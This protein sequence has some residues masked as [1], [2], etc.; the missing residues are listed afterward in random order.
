MEKKPRNRLRVLLVDDDED[1][2]LLTK[3]MLADCAY[4]SDRREPVGFRLDWVSSYE[5]AL[6][7]FEGQQHDVYLL[8]YHLGSRDGLQLLREVTAKGCTK[9]V[10]L[11]TGRGSYD[12]DIEAMKAGATDYLVKGEL[13]APLLERTIRYSIERKRAEEEIRQSA[14]RAQGLAALS[15]AFAEASLDL[16]EVLK[17]IPRR[18]AQAFGD[19][20][21]LRLVSEDGQWLTPVAF[22][23]PRA[24]AHLLG[25]KELEA[26]RQ[27]AQEGLAGQVFRTSRPLLVEEAPVPLRPSE[28]EP[29]HGFEE[30]EFYPW[31]NGTPV[32]SL[33]IVPLSAQGRLIG[34]L[35]ALRFQA[36]RPYTAGDVV[37]FQDVAGR[38]VLA[39]ENALLHAEVQKTAITDALTE[40][41]NRRGLFELGRREIERARRFS[42]PLSAIMVDLDHFK[43]VNDTHGHAAGDQVLRI[44]G[45][46]LRSAV[47]DVDI[48]GR[49]GGDEFIILLP[50]TDLYVA[51]TVAERIRQRIAVPFLLEVIPGDRPEW[52]LT[53]SLGVAGLEGEAQDLAMLIDR[54]D[55]ASYLAKHAGRNCVRVS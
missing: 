24:T 26:R 17:I 22:G 41:Y 23:P 44:A 25:E 30:L 33:L 43:T 9:P 18:I 7:A 3:S 11:M 46:R 27:P 10:I 16:Q 14:E 19:G 13:S 53:A 55:A 20:C 6:E 4:L 2:Y 28:R 1:E 42:R 21:I 48:L 38:A 52:G 37:F 54:A 50:E 12:L 32:Q 34:T 45:H 5:A 35:S 39:I 29:A 51:C 15:Q 8:D 40:V 36:S 49:Y 47:R 31:V